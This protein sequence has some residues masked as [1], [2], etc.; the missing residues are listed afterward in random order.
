M[1]KS[2]EP[3]SSCRFQFQSAR[4]ISRNS[5]VGAKMISTSAL[6]DFAFQACAL[7]C[8]CLV[9]PGK[10]VLSILHHAEIGHWQA[11]L[12][13]VWE[14]GWIVLDLKSFPPQKFHDVDHV[15]NPVTKTFE[16]N[17]I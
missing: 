8:D 6:L 1:A 4:Q 3:W 5:I 9:V 16:L 7:T 11:K 17:V 2:N 10:R 13:Q 14:Q 12:I 15:L